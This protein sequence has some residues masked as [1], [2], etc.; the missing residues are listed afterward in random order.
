MPKIK[1]E[2]ERNNQEQCQ[3]WDRG[4]IK[5][6]AGLDIPPEQR[7]D[8]PLQAAARAF[9]VKPF[10]GR[11]GDHIPIQPIDQTRPEMSS[12]QLKINKSSETA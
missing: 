12:H 9:Q 10:F 2:M 1:P 4:R 8:T 6:E 11:T 5:A 7:D 3:Q